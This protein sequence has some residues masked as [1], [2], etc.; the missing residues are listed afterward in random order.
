MTEEWWELETG[1]RGTLKPNDALFLDQAIHAAFGLARKIVTAP[2]K[3]LRNRFV[4][5]I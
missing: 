5:D 2:E 4:R 1:M 3:Q